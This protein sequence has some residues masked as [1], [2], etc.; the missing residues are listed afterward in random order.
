MQP[1]TQIL[2]PIDFSDSTQRVIELAAD[3]ARHYEAP[4]LLLHACEPVTYLRP[5]GPVELDPELQ[6]RALASFKAQL[7]TLANS[8]R[9]AGVMRVETKAVQGYAIHEI[10]RTS[11]EF[12][13][14]LIVMGTHGR[15][16]LKH[17]LIGSVAENVVR[18]APCPVLTVR[19]SP[20]RA[21]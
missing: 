13:S 3:L 14:C 2:V 1:F 18:S 10:V 7:D 17:L 5:E 12:A 20:A 21:A 6:Q 15:T 4:L 16:G 9:A 8:A 11:K 19:S